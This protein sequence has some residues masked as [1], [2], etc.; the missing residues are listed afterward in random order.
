MPSA[1]HPV[2]L[3]WLKVTPFMFPPLAGLG[4]E[5]QSG[6]H[7]HCLRPGSNDVIRGEGRRRG[8][9]KEKRKEEEKG[10]G[11]EKEKKRRRRRGRSGRKGG[12][13]RGET[14]GTRTCCE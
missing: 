5:E 3:D 8:K 12:A 4:R 2:T 6:L 13:G 7:R 11:R 9:V 1:H 10:G 14:G